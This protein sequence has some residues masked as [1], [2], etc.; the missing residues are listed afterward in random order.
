M[1]ELPRVPLALS[2]AKTD[3]ARALI[4]VGIQEQRAVPVAVL[5]RADQVIE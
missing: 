3:E 5:T 4:C 2:L 1:V